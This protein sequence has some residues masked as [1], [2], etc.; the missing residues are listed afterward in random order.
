MAGESLIIIGAGLAGLSTGSYAQ[1]NG[2][3]SRIF[4][5]HSKPGGVAATW[6]RQGYVIEGGIHFLMG[7]RPGQSAYELYRELGTAQVNTFPDITTYGRFIDESSGR[8]LDVTTGLDRLADDL[9]GVSENDT[10]LVSGLVA[11][12]RVMQG[13]DLT[14]MALNKPPELTRVWDR[15]KFVWDLR[16]L[17]KYYRG[18]YARSMGEFVQE[19]QDPWL[20][21]VLGNMFMPE[22]PVWF[23]LMIWGLLADRQLGLLKG[24]SAGF[25][26]P[27]EKRYLELG[28]QVTYRATVEEIL[29]END[30]AVGVRLADGSEHRADVVVSAADGYGT[31]F[32]MLKGR[33]LNDK[34]R[35]RFSKW[36][37][38]RPVVM[39]SFGV[40]REFNDEPWL[41][42]IKLKQ[43]IK[44]GQGEINEIIVRIF[45]YSQEFAPPGKT[46]V[47]V[48]FES[49][50]DFWNELQKDRPRYDDEKQRV[51]TEVL[52]RL[53]AR[54][55]GIYALV[56]VTDV[57]TPYT[58]WRYTLNYR[59]AYEGWLPTPRVINTAIPRT[60]PGLS[61]FYMAGQWIMPGGGVPPVIISGRHVVQIL[62]HR[63]RKPFQ[64][65]V[66]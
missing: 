60:L 53:E 51:A 18:K 56:E 35:D 16:G 62:C 50:W 49:E 23:V 10:A 19:V 2:Y 11:G 66:P 22:V 48:L 37:L 24:G 29:V 33:Y 20:R 25:V 55:P 6:K 3:R 38:I 52:S 13:R 14:G 5:H 41:S 46:V 9:K 8:Y 4:E 42:V 61:N 54:Y 36:E 32:K 30:R 59:G 65:S 7:H 34:I 17:L 39:V 15:L 58:T 12:V 26:R 1:M 28:G 47:Q 27:I 40:A 45:N 44:L 57:A 21:W 63:D 31:I 64:A 43:P